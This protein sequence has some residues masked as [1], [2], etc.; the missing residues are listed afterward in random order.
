MEMN[1]LTLD[2]NL[3]RIAVR[4]VGR[5]IEELRQ[6]HCL[7]RMAGLSSNENP[8]GPSPR[9]V[10]AVKQAV[11]KVHR[12]PGICE[13]DLRTKI[14]RPMGP[15]F[16]QDNVLV[17][18][19]SSEILRLVC[20][21]FLF[22][23]GESVVCSA[24]FPLYRLFTEMFGGQTVLVDSKEYAYDLPAMAD[25]ISDET[26][27]VFVCNPN[28]PTG[29]VLTQR[30]VD[31]FMKR[32]PDR[33]LVVFDE[34]YREYV[35][36]EDY[37][38]VRKY[39]KEGRNVLITRTFSKIHGLA[40]LRVGYGVGAKELV[41]YLR[42]ALSAFH[43]GTL[44]LIGAA[45]SLDDDEH[46]RRSREHNSTEMRFLY[47][48]FDALDLHYLPTQGNFILLVEL[49][50]DIETLWEALVRRGV[51]VTK[52]AAYRVPGAIRVTIGTREEN[53]LLVQ[54]LEQ[55]LREPPET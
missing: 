45:A 13:R 6:E 43:V 36:V 50:R 30:Q 17:A 8:L 52:A 20:Q 23:G 5:P 47:E 49:G 7:P 40:G 37:A 33:V 32:V 16:D 25:E 2:P 19:G 34:A 21:A 35:E 39:I 27:L 1:E 24:T 10:E 55:A 22:D 11:D 3:L 12:Y 41:E 15:A 28:N 48:Q 29:T 4:K 9:A 46:V 44:G 53:E 51:V 26:R 14:C 42:R 18:N 31:D 38:D 54:A